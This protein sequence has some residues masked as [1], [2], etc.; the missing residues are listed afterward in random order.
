VTTTAD[1]SV[2]P[3]TDRAKPLRGL[4]VVELGGDVSAYLGRML[5][6]LGADVAVPAASLPAAETPSDA[7]GYYRVTFAAGKRGLADDALDQAGRAADIVVADSVAAAGGRERVARWT[8][9]RSG[10]ILVLLTP[11][12]ADGPY[13]DR[14]SSDLVNIAMGGYLYMTGP[15][16]GVPLKATAPFISYRH[17][18]NHA[19]GALL[20][21][22]RRR[23]LT[24]AGAVIDQAIRQT[25]MWMLT[26]TYQYWE[27][28]R[29]NLVRKGAD[30][31]AG[32]ATIRLPSLYHCKDGLI[33]W[34]LLSGRLGS[35]SMDKLV[36]WMAEDGMA[37]EW[38]QQ[39]DWLTLEFTSLDHAA[40]YLELFAAFLLTK[41]RQELLE[42]AIRDGFMLAP[43]NPIAD[44]LTDPQL[45]ARGA[46]QPFELAGQSYR[47][48][49]APVQIGGVDWSLG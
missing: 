18:C 35:G 48:P 26:H 41:T 6:D 29:V 22:L 10:Q 12:G 3:F 47:L 44:L 46:W 11:F 1:S 21:A 33:V 16:G 40:R 9:E 8:E 45:E 27:H 34:M 49:R 4:R 23:R 5:A 42:R 20:L 28:E 2:Q 19:L 15:L 24:G 39:T 43:V 30:R 17:A 31:D 36:A 25:G 7:P 37:P 38:L 14:P 13:A 32:S